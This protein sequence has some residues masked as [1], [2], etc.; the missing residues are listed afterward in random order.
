VADCDLT[1][2]WT[3]SESAHEWKCRGDLGLGARGDGRNRA[4]AGPRTRERYAYISWYRTSHRTAYQNWKT[5]VWE[6]QITTLFRSSH[7]V[8][9]HDTIYRSCLLSVYFIYSSF[10][11]FSSSWLIALLSSQSAANLHPVVSLAGWQSSDQLALHATVLTLGPA[12]S[13]EGAQKRNR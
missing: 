3:T 11:S 10:L 8:Y 6:V 9:L 4:N 12:C 2:T 13:L 5:L 1:E 7:H